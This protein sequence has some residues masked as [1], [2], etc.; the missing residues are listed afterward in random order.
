MDTPKKG[1]ILIPRVG[2]CGDLSG[3]EG[4]FEGYILS[5]GRDIDN[6]RKFEWGY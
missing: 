5:K 4:V 6:F 3:G 1:G 2:F